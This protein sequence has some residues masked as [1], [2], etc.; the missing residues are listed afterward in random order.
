MKSRI[1]LF[2]LAMA[3]APAALY[4]QAP[5]MNVL[6][7]GIESVKPGKGGAHD[8]L[9]AEW[10]SAIYAA[11]PASGYLGM[12]T[13][14]G[15]PQFWYATLF[16]SWADYE[17]SQASNPG[18]QAAS[19]RFSP[20]EADLLSETRDLV[21]VRIDSL[22]YGQPRDIA[23]MRYMSVTRVTV[24]LGHYD[25]WAEARMVAKHAHEAAQLTDEYSIWRVVAGAPTGTY[26]QFSARKSLAELDEGVTIHGPAYQAAIGAEG[27]KKL[28]AAQTNAVA[29]SQADQLSF[30]PAQSVMSA[31]MT[32]SDP[33]Y[34]AHKPAA[35]KKP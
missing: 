35:V 10:A 1:S 28:D 16:N 12:K 29:F 23:Q 6:T 27:Q 15:P 17:K 19:A 32:K 20:Q 21:L 2:A 13:M 25:E 26:Y 14:T 22:G 30:A 31:E 33:A 7:I 5:R 9:E 11:K 24:R 34:W 3:M 8:K 18:Q 4:A